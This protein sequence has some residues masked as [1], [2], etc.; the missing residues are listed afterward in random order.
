LISCPFSIKVPPSPGLIVQNRVYPWSTKG[1]GAIPHWY[2]LA[3][4]W[5]LLSKK[6][7]LQLLENGVLMAFKWR[8]CSGKYSAARQAKS[9]KLLNMTWHYCAIPAMISQSDSSPEGIM[10]YS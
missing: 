9:R 6:S 8:S 4:W 10:R 2:E 5:I 3:S 1:C 7:N